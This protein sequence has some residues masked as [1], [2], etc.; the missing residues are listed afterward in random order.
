MPLDCPYSG[1]N[2]LEG[3]GLKKETKGFSSWKLHK[4]TARDALADA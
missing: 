4:Q 3:N 1:D 2:A